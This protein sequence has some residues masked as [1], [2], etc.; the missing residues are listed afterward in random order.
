MAVN[1]ETRGRRIVATGLAQGLGRG[2]GFLASL[3]VFPIVLDSIGKAEFGI[4]LTFASLISLLAVF[5]FGLGSGSVSR[6]ASAYGTADLQ[7]VEQIVSSMF[8]VLVVIGTGM[9]TIGCAVAMLVDWR[10]LIDLPRGLSSGDLAWSIAITIAAVAMSFPLGLAARVQLAMQRGYATT[11]SLLATAAC[12]IVGAVVV[13]ALSPS[14]VWFTFA[15]MTALV[16][17][18]AGNTIAVLLTGPTYLRPRLVSFRRK[19]A[20]ELMRTGA[21]FF[22]L[23][24]AGAVA[25]E[26]DAVVIT[27]VIGPSAAADYG[28]GY[29]LFVLIPLVTSLFLAP[30]WPAY[31]E[32][33]ATGD[34]VWMR[35]TFSTSLRLSVMCAIAGATLLALLQGV[36]IRSWL[37]TSISLSLM[38]VVAL[39]LLVFVN[40]YSGPVAAVLNG[41]GRVRFQVVTALVMVVLN[42]TLSVALASSVGI[43]GPPLGTVIAQVVAILIPSYW[44]IYRR[45]LRDD[46][47]L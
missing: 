47:R 34:P 13:R 26:T 11:P 36:I 35:R 37:G 14:L 23:A 8:V 43:A 18:P 6:L 39:S 20:R 42:V 30:L 41:V 22:L 44:L 2:V 7:R 32:A 21:G 4:W 10:E 31:A 1:P 45:V 29:R 9:A 24:I 25:Y 15:F 3:L 33:Q 19:V 17:G 5:D 12:E 27:L 40:A 16:V 28:V 46:P 38:L